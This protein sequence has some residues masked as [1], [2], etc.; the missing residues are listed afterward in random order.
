MKTVTFETWWEAFKNAEEEWK[1]WDPPALARAAFNAG[2][3]E[4]NPRVWRYQK[5]KGQW[6]VEFLDRVQ[7]KD[8]GTL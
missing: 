8:E 5:I 3:T 1:I 4:G 2:R 6:V 7:E